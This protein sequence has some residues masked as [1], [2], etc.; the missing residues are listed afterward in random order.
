M[1]FTS[2]MAGRRPKLTK[3]WNSRTLIQYIHFTVRLKRQNS[4]DCEVKRTEIGDWGC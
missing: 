4:V 2:E 3:I 1:L